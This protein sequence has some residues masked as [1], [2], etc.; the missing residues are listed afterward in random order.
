M[1]DMMGKIEE[2]R[3]ILE[4]IASKIPGYSGYKEREDRRTADKLLREIIADRYEEQ[5]ARLSGLQRDLIEAGGIEHV[6]RLEGAAIKLRTFIDQM[7]T[8]SYGY[9]GFFDAVKVN[10][11]E[12]QALY[13]FDNALLENAAAIATAVDNVAA[14]LES[15]GLPAAIRNL[16]QLAQDCNDT[17]T[18]R[19]EVLT[20]GA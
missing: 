12:L 10:E 5:W 3:N 4:K 14:S 15:D 18:R 6:D 1:T 16:T 8:A 2:G 19:G 17:F 20:G 11:K 13:A 9:S 7:K